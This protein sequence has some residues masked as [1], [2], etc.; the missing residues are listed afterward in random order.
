[1][2][3]GPSP[4]APPLAGVRVLDLTQVIAGPFCTTMLADMGAE[5]LKL[6]RRGEGDQLR[7]V[8]R[9]KGRAE[10]EDYFYANNRS[11]K[12]IELDLKDPADL[13]VA[14]DLAAAADVLVENFAAGTTDRLGIGYQ[15]VRERNPLIVYCAISGFGQTGPY[16]DRTALDPV[17]QA[18]SGL[19]SVTGMED[20]DPIMVGAPIGDVIAGMFGAFAIVNALR[21]AERSGI[22]QFIDISMQAALLAA[23]GPRMGETLQAGVVPRRHGNQ[24]PMRVPAD[25]Y[26][27]S[28]DRYIS[29]MCHGDRQWEPLCRAVERPEWASDARFSTMQGRVEYRRLLTQRFRDIFATRPAADWIARLEA[30]RIPYAFV[31]NYADALDDPQVHHRGQVKRI[32]HPVSGPIRVVGP[33]WAMSE[34]SET[35]TAPP[36]LGQHTQ[37]IL[38]SW[39]GLDHEPAAKPGERR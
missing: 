8:G 21:T 3:A 11:K 37:E 17:I 6:E 16:R 32:E 27:T 24:N 33:P 26:R 18:V 7:A 30:E 5:V 36:L 4:S 12:S 9:Y 31:N 19:M 25:T 10:H 34:Y 28:D 38:A 13:A 20:G 35:M 22:G 15:D 39:L 1:M 14:L 2:S 23:I 29:V